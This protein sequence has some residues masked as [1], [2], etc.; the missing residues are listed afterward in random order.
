MLERVTL[1]P[2]P[3]CLFYS[4]FSLPR[5]AVGGQERKTQPTALEDVVFVCCPPTWEPNLCPPWPTRRAQRTAGV[6]ERDS[7]V[8]ENFP[9]KMSC[10]GQDLLEVSETLPKCEAFASKC[11]MQV[12]E[13]RVFSHCNLR[14]RETDNKNSFLRLIRRWLRA[15]GHHEITGISSGKGAARPGPTAET[16]GRHCRASKSPTTAEGRTWGIFKLTESCVLTRL[17]LARSILDAC[18]DQCPSGIWG[19]TFP[20]LAPLN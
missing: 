14:Q 18:L 16:L 9:P 20:L 1:C 2:H 17:N 12:R 3:L 10:V 7:R 11:E 15:Q 19:R 13:E 6:A 5:A 8:S 4:P